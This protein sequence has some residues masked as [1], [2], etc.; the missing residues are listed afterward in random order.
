MTLSPWRRQLTDIYLYGSISHRLQSLAGAG[1][2]NDAD[3]IALDWGLAGTQF[4]VRA[5]AL[6]RMKCCDELTM[7]SSANV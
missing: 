2:I 1:R 5:V 4:G 3:R 7:R 6:N